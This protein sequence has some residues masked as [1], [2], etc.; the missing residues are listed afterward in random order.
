MA[1]IIVV[2]RRNYSSLL[3]APQ[4]CGS[5]WRWTGSDP[6]EKKRSRQ[7]KPGPDPTFAKKILIDQNWLK[8]NYKGVLTVV[9][10]LIKSGIKPGLRIWVWFKTG[11]WTVTEW[12]DKQLHIVASLAKTRRIFTK[13]SREKKSST[14][15]QA[16]NGLMAIGT[17][18]YIRQDSA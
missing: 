11:S 5:G 17:F 18:F 1:Q 14:S 12:E 4:G 16:I 8:L 10:I 3:R 7:E 15:G 6:R 2:Q 13:E 9:L